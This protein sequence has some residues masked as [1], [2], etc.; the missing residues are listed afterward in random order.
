MT[1]DLLS[2]EDQLNFFEPEVWL[3]LQCH[4]LL[5]LC[6]RLESELVEVKHLLTVA[7]ELDFAVGHSLAFF[8]DR[9][10]FLTRCLLLLKHGDFRIVF[11][12][13]CA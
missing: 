11:A 4:R 6:L 13:K 1:E 2:A 8:V 3:S 10:G 12:N 9:G 5:R 7:G